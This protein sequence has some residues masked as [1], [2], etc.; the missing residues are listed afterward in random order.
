MS[1][2]NTLQALPARVRSAVKVVPSSCMFAALYPGQASRVAGSTQVAT[3]TPRS[4]RKARGLNEAAMGGL[5]RR[6]GLEL[7]LIYTDHPEFQVRASITESTGI[8]F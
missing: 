3:A 8:L 6:W 7:E 5:G 2:P 1:V 4:A